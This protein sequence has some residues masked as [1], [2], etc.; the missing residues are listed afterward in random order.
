MNWTYCEVLYSQ[1]RL[2]RTRKKTPASSIYGIIR[3]MHAEE[4]DSIKAPTVYESTLLMKQ[5]HFRTK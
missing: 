1:T 3:Y 5:T 4:L 2:Y